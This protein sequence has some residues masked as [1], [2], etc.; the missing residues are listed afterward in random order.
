MKKLKYRV[1]GNPNWTEHY[2]SRATDALYFLMGWQ[3]AVE[4]LGYLVDKMFIDGEELNLGPKNK[5]IKNEN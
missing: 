1:I 2:F 4:S 5:R 3:E